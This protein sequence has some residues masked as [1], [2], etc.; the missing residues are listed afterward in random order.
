MMPL[1]LSRDDGAMPLARARAFI[2]AYE[3]MKTA[4]E[5]AKAA[6]AAADS[7]YSVANRAAKNAV[8]AK[9][10]QADECLWASFAVC[11]ALR[12][13]AIQAETALM[14]AER[15]LHECNMSALSFESAARRAE[16]RYQ[17]A[18]RAEEGTCRE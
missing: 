17:R 1:L 3:A 12:D 7:A 8:F 2:E 9:K 13:D 4:Q 14:E 10:K 5:E 16:N 6:R 15:I 18:L 11:A